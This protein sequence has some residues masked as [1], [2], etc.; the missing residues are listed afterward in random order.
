MTVGELIQR[1]QLFDS[2]M[3]VQ[4]EIEVM[5]CMGHDGGEYCY[6]SNELRTYDPYQF[7]EGQ[8]NVWTGN[9]DK[10]GHHISEKRDVLVIRG[11]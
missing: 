5:N 4:I 9:R 3:D 2:N 8:H 1:L 10:R 6:C 7:I 11:N